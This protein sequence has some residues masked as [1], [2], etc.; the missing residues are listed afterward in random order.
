MTMSD[1][2]AYA[3]QITDSNSVAKALFEKNRADRQQFLD[4]YFDE[5][6]STS[7]VLKSGGIEIE[8]ADGGISL[9]KEDRSMLVTATSDDIRFKIWPYPA[10]EAVPLTFQ[11]TDV[12]GA[13]TAK[14]EI[15]TRIFNWLKLTEKSRTEE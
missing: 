4:T 1:I 5:N 13:A 10:V 11:T 3:R 12:D 2:D 9:R 8:R 7:S 6:V 14:R 15:S